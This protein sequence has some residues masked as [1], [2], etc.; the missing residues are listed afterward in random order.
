M[1]DL[2]SNA[3]CVGVQV[4]LPSILIYYLK[5]SSLTGKALRS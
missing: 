5:A 3:Y 4:S 1:L 2:G